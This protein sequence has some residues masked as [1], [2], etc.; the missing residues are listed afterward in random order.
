MCSGVVVGAMF[1]IC[2]V[3]LASYQL[4]KRVTIQMA[5]ELAERRR[6]LTSPGAA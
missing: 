2:T 5:D 6:K 1:A 3:L 4:D